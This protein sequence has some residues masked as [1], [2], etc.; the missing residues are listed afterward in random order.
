MH[1]LVGYTPSQF[2]ESFDIEDQ[3]KLHRKME[4]PSAHVITQHTLGEVISP[5]L[6]AQVPTPKALDEAAAKHCAV[7]MM[8]SMSSGIGL[9]WRAPCNALASWSWR[10]RTAIKLNGSA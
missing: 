4:M 8:G 2:D 1:S 9:R 10:W 6:V 3:F 7:G 5:E